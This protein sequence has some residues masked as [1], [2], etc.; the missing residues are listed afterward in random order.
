MVQVIRTLC[1]IHDL[2]G[3]QVDADAGTV[4]VKFGRTEIEADLCT[5]CKKHYESGLELLIKVGRKPGRAAPTRRTS[6]S[7]AVSPPADGGAQPEKKPSKTPDEPNS[8]DGTFVCRAPVDCDRKVST[9]DNPGFP[10]SQGRGMHERRA[11]DYNANGKPS[12]Q[13]DRVPVDA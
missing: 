1:D 8:P 5:A 9:S 13:R 6:G 11:H 12:R 2:E 4:P 7:S 3:D 10:T